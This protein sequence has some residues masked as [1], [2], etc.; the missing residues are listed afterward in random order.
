MICQLCLFLFLLSARASASYVRH[1]NDASMVFL[2]PDA[3]TICRNTL[4]AS[5]VTPSGR[6][7]AFATCI[8]QNLDDYALSGANSG[9]TLLAL[10]PPALA[11][12]STGRMREHSLLDSG[13]LE[14][15]FKKQISQRVEA[16]I[17]LLSAAFAGT[18]SP[19][20]ALR[21]I[22]QTLDEQK[23]VPSHAQTKRQADKDH[24][25]TNAEDIYLPRKY[26]ST[27]TS[28]IPVYIV[29][30]GTMATILYLW[31]IIGF[32]TV[33]TWACNWDILVVMWATFRAC[34]LLFET[35]IL[36]I[37]NKRHAKYKLIST[38]TPSR[39]AQPNPAYKLDL[40]A[41]DAE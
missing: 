8:L 5:D 15:L 12:F 41:Q 28:R 30:F 35:L 29:L 13:L 9:T 2:S 37:I 18:H 17:L 23:N 21:K 6:C 20:L 27:L 7:F 19:G 34:P 1:Y 10:I 26:F 32:R 31:C 24:V 4:N 25:K 3:R 11:V 22:A 14:R 16:I 38:T 39:S 33:V 36:L 40:G